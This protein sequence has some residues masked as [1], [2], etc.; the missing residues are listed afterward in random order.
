MPG[1]GL[2]FFKQQLLPDLMKHCQR[3]NFGDAESTRAS[4][5]SANDLLDR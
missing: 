2:K 4:G 5:G 1:L 3:V